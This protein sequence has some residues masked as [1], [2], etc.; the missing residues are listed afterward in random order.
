MVVVGF[1]VIAGSLFAYQKERW[2][3]HYAMGEVNRIGS[4]RIEL[5]DPEGKPF[6]AELNHETKVYDGLRLIS[7]HDLPAGVG[8]VVFGQRLGLERIRADVVR[9]VMPPQEI[10]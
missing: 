3:A 4:Q 1:F 9:T 8:V 10:E 7:P 2:D 5:M 6:F